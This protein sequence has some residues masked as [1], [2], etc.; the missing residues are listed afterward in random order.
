MDATP[1]AHTDNLDELGLEDD[2]LVETSE[3]IRLPDYRPLRFRLDSEPGDMVP[4]AGRE[5]PGAP[6]VKD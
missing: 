2:R 3:K 5:E 1:D 4:R 6:V